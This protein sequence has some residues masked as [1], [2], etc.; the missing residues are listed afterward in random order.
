MLGWKQGE[1]IWIKLRI[2]TEQQH[3]ITSNWILMHNSGD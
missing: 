3:V 1:N 2:D